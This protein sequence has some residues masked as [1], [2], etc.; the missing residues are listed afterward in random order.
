MDQRPLGPFIDSPYGARRRRPRAL[1]ILMLIMLTVVLFVIFKIIPLGSGETIMNDRQARKSLAEA[2]TMESQSLHALSA[3]LYQRVANSKRVSAE[4]RVRAA[5][6]LA[7]VYREMGRL[8]QVEKAL[9]M[10]VYNTPK[11]ADQ[12]ALRDELANLRGRSLA[13]DNRM[14]SGAADRNPYPLPPE[15]RMLAQIGEE[16]V[17]MEEILYA[18]GQFN[19]MRNPT[20][21]E[22]RPFV[23]MYLD[24]AL[25]ADEARRSGL[26]RKPGTVY[27]LRVRRM[28]GL[29]QAMTEKMIHDLKEPDAKT[30]QAYYDSHKALFSIPARATVGEI[31][32]EERA[33]AEK[34]AKAL[35]QGQK[36]DA[37]ARKYSLDAGKL[38]DGYIMGQITQND[39]GIPGYG[40]NPRLVARLLAMNNGATTGP[41]Q[42]ARGLHWLRIVDK[43]P[44]KARPFAEVRD[45]VLLSY[46]KQ[47]LAESRSALLK[48][49]R[50]ERPL[51]ILDTQMK[52]AL[53][54]D[55]A[56]GATT[57]TAAAPPAPATSATQTAAPPAPAAAAAPSGKNAPERNAP[58]RGSQER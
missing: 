3:D 2:E 26:D 10:A 24:M 48:K 53:E 37:V 16:S 23:R 9:E 35:G 55:D 43:T 28:M 52:G 51:Q 29:N 41:L 6:G 50:Q 54:Q 44:A 7:G 32:V 47:K 17:S 12:E 27:D 1:H 25:L 20:P 14:T 57:S 36:F 15:A 45:E 5:H 4:L 31:V 49:L 30:L 18:W 11:G 39:P 13:A 22:L 19:G 46:Q 38:K 33:D 58:R 8:D 34:V 40:P 56:A 21:D 42:T